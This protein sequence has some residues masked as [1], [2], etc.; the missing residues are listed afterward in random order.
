MRSLLRVVSLLLLVGRSLVVMVVV[1]LLPTG[2]LN[3]DALLD[4]RVVGLEL[5]LSV[6]R[7]VQ[8]SLHR[9]A[10]E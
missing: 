8:Y 3:R 4:A 10:G 2:F 7:E 1:R 9:L 6:G 5:Q